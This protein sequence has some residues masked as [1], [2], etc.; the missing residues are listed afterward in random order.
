MP[1]VSGEADE[2]ATGLTS[3]LAVGV[4]FGAGTFA[5]WTTCN[6]LGL[7]LLEDWVTEDVRSTS[8]TAFGAVDR[9][10]VLVLAG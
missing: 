4:G 2:A 10:G 6:G 5:M 9:A 1:G 3:G 8:I 7:G